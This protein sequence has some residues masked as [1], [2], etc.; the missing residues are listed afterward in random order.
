MG[1]LQF[2]V[3][4]IPVR[5]CP[6]FWLFMVFFSGMYQAFTIESLI[7][8]VVLFKG[9]LVHE[10]GHA[11]T[12]AYFGT[13]PEI[14][15]E[16][17]GGV[18]RYW[19]RLSAKQHLI[20][21]INGPLLEA[22]LAG[23]A[24]AF[25]KSGIFIGKPHLHFFFWATAIIN[26]VWSLLNLL[27]ID[28]LDGGQIAHYLFAKRFGAKGPRYAFFL[29]LGTAFI[30]IPFLVLAKFYFFSL[31]LALCILRKGKEFKEKLI[32]PK[33]SNLELYHEGNQALIQGNLSLAKANFKTLLKVKDS[34]Y[35]NSAREGLAKV[36]SEEGSHEEAYSLLKKADPSALRGGKVLL[37]KLAFQ[38]GNYSLVTRFAH[39]IYEQDP[40]FSIASM[41]ASSFA[42]LG[43]LEHAKAWKE[44][45][46][47]FPD[48]SKEEMSEIQKI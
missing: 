11:L 3:F 7:L 25:Y 31:F 15:I 1:I 37:C 43:Q 13:K 46:L 21:T 26:T 24:F 19:G 39:D 16:A 34:H 14:T 38:K 32:A 23:V 20:I 17:F 8:G 33:R 9:I 18:A 28:P 29:S 22:C 6:S 36:Y 12:A 45:A 47:Q 30:V 41:I 4:G 48:V 40:S 10:L 27:P 35:A 5:V 42:K 44:C 2:R